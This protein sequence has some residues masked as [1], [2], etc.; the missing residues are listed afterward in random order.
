MMPSIGRR[1]KAPKDHEPEEKEHREG[2]LIR[3]LR[4]SVFSDGGG[5]KCRDPA[6]RKEYR[7]REIA[8]LQEQNLNSV[9][10]HKARLAL[11]HECSYKPSEDLQDVASKARSR[12]S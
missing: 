12:S 11:G 2:E 3:P 7:R 9:E 1:T 5:K 10:R 8:D 4:G 6:N